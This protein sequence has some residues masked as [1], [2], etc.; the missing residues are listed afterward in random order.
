MW[1]KLTPER[2]STSLAGITPTPVGNTSLSA[3][4]TLSIKDHPHTRGEY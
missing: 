2:N 3:A 4:L 1:G